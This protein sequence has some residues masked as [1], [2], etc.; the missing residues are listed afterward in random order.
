MKEIGIQLN[1]SAS[2]VCKAFKKAG[3]SPK[4]VK[5][6][7]YA[8]TEAEADFVRE[9]WFK[10]TSGWIGDQIGKSG[11]SIRQWAQKHIGRK[12]PP[13]DELRLKNK[14]CPT[15]E[16]EFKPKQSSQVYCSFECG[17]KSR[18][19]LEEIECLNCGKSFKPSQSKIKFCSHLCS[20]E[21][22]QKQHI[23][24]RPFKYK[25]IKMRSS[26]E[27]KFAE[28][29]DSQELDWKY[30]PTFFS[31]MGDK[32]YA[33]DFYIPSEDTFYEVKGWMKD[34]AK[35]KIEAMSIEHPSVKLVLLQKEDLKELG[36]Q[37]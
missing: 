12:R 27:V 33:P 16:K 11:Q 17:I 20:Q 25:D 34:G 2:W 8:Y 24:V 3:Y 18:T 37:L 35:R 19:Y 36:I 22:F 32:R 30:E 31:V 7:K 5:Y 21:G 29:L 23:S 15:C 1:C 4:R 9:H 26:W 10:E 14:K 28:W 13:P 6:N